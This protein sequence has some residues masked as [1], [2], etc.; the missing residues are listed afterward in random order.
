MQALT[1][2]PRTSGMTT[3]AKKQRGPK[4]YD[5]QRQWGLQPSSSGS[6]TIGGEAMYIIGGHV[7]SSGALAPGKA[8]DAIGR[9]GQA[10]AKRR[11]EERD[12]EKALKELL[13]RERASGVGG[14]AAEVVKAA[15][16]L[17]ADKRGQT[18][19]DKN[20]NGSG[21]S[22]LASAQ[23]KG[24]GKAREGDSASNVRENKDEPKRPSPSGTNSEDEDGKPK[25]SYSA[26]MVKRLGFD[27]VLLSVKV[28]GRAQGQ[29]VSKKVSC[30]PR[31]FCFRETVSLNINICLKHVKPLPDRAQSGAIRLGPPPGKKV[32]SGVTVPSSAHN[33]P[34]E[35]AN[36]DASKDSNLTGNASQI[37]RD[38]S[39][40]KVDVD[41]DSELEIGSDE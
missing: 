14:G 11:V 16:A 26:E 24:K 4:D 20:V 27:P 18:D 5:P 33:P 37:S 17:V 21:K 34:R 35:R 7:A 2:A 19:K 9:E 41:S 1:C 3:T 22:G 38:N 25:R 36:G 31:I 6:M 39:T 15:R 12:S 30:K 13:G 8:A 32:R 29:S 23:M 28:G 40:S 10:R